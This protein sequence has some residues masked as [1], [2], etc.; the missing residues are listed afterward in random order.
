MATLENSN[1]AK[2][3]AEVLIEHGEA[4]FDFDKENKLSYFVRTDDVG[5]ERLYWGKDL[6]RALEEAGARIGDVITATRVGSK[7][8]TVKELQEQPDG[9]KQE[10]VIDARRNTWEIAKHGHNAA[11]VIKEYDRLVKSPESRR[12]LEKQNPGLVAARDSAVVEHKRQRLQHE[13]AARSARQSN[14]L[15]I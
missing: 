4:P 7:H 8:V 9:S 15:R 1:V 2:A 5:E 14:S 11:V 13:L 3:S 6:P 12:E 10:V